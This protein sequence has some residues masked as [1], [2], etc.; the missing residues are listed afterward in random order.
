MQTDSPT[1]NAV[2]SRIRLIGGAFK[3]EL[4]A[5]GRY[6]RLGIAAVVAVLVALIVAGEP[7]AA[8]LTALALGALV[9]GY[10]RPY[11]LAPLVAVLLPAGERIEVVHAQVSPLEA[12]VGG[13]ALGYL[14]RVLL[15]EEPFRME[16][17]DWVFAVLVACVGLSTIGPV[18]NS[19]RLREFL[20]WGALGVV[21]HAARVRLGERRALKALLG[22]LA[23]STVVEASIALF[24]YLDRWSDRFSLLHGALVYPLP[25]GTL[26]HP[27]GLAQFL[28][29][30]VLVVLALALAERGA[31]RQFGFLAAAAGS[32]ALVVTFSRASW[33]AF[34]VGGAVYLLERRTRIPALIVAGVASAGALALVLLDAGA[35]GS[36]VSSLFRGEAG[37]L[38]DFRVELAGR[39]ARIAWDHPLAGAGR[40]EELGDYAGRPAL[41]THPHNLFLGLAVFFGI[42]AALAFAGLALIALRAAW[43]GF[44]AREDAHRLM[45]LGFLALLVAFLVNGL[46]EYPFWNT[47][48]T[49]LI[50]LALAAALACERSAPS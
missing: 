30:S 28:V 40:F 49:V 12:V 32:F 41:A 50:V 2:D 47:S 10:A 42:P 14:V 8:V 46:F 45:S 39:A 34:A 27:N 37:G 26:D 33:I 16:V 13:G 29:L 23:V 4:P 35:I 9:V 7:A 48:L 17:P 44:R 21:F 11:L 31:L 24:E 15:R 18:D 22:A 19:D 3:S 5:L 6:A 38:Y 36:R 43:R 20:V 25:T 1:G